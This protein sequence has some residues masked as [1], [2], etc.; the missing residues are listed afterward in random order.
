MG[1]TV[2]KHYDKSDHHTRRNDGA[3]VLFLRACL[4]NFCTYINNIYYACLRQEQKIAFKSFL[5]QK[6][7]NRTPSIDG[8]YCLESS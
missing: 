8:E 7:K 6:I 5:N 3:L 2:K 1:N 4:G